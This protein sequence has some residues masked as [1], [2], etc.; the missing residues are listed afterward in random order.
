[1]PNSPGIEYEI[2]ALDHE[3]GAV[4]RRTLNRIMDHYKAAI[5]AARD[6]GRTEGAAVGADDLEAAYAAG[7]ERA[8]VIVDVFAENDAPA[9]QAAAAIRA[10]EE[11]MP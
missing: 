11:A 5:A 1:M 10:D 4:Q 9:D 7:K 2:A 3:L 6:R 8:A